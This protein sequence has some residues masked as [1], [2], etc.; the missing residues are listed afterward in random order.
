MTGVQRALDSKITTSDRI[1]EA[2]RLP[3]ASGM[4]TQS[5][6]VDKK[7]DPYTFLFETF[8]NT[9]NL[10]ESQNSQNATLADPFVAVKRKRDKK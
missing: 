7:M 3:L 8:L 10:I 5:A 4:M 2:K 1:K 9:D 6:G